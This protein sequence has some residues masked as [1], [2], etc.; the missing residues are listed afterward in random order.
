MNCQYVREKYG[1]PA[2][3]GRRVIA[4]GK[5]GVIAED[6]GHYIGVNFD[7]DK[8]GVIFNVHPKSNV[9]YLEMDKVRKMTCSQKR[10]QDYLKVADCFNSFRHF[11]ICNTCKAQICCGCEKVREA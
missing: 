11:V 2:A 5:P 4:S 3:I 1:V 9:E 8:P 10:Y 6:R 7:S